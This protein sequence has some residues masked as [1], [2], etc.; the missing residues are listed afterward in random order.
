MEKL[1]GAAAADVETLHRCA[2][3]GEPGSEGKTLKETGISDR[4]LAEWSPS[5]RAKDMPHF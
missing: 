3:E 2:P 1:F 4:T 5:A